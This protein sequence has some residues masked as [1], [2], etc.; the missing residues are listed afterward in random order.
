[1]TTPASSPTDDAAAVRSLLG[2]TNPVPEMSLTPG[3][4]QSARAGLAMVRVAP[5]PPRPPRGRFVVAGAVATLSVATLIAVVAI[6]A[7]RDPATTSLATGPGAK[8]VGA[9]VAATQASGT[10]RGLLTITHAGGTVTASGTGD[11]GS[12]EA[13]AEIALAGDPRSGTVTV[14]RTWTGIYAR[15]PEGM[16]PLSADRPWVSVD[17]PTLARLTQLALG[18]GAAQITGAPLDALTYLRGVSGDVTLVGPDTTRGEPTT[19]Y[20]GAVDPTK[21]AAQ[22]PEAIRAHAPPAA[23]GPASLPADLWIDGQGRLRKLVIT[24]HSAAGSAE[25]SAVVPPAGP[26]PTTITLETITLELWDFGIPV[27]VSAPPADQVADVSGL[28][29]TFVQNLGRP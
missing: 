9:A 2:P 24:E 28:L 14:L 23:A 15:L 16:N 19:H 18:D 3:E 22:L 1:V 17:A 29:G 6:P 26:G 5:A 11:F 8:A 4:V 10:A 7:G 20:R 21:A 27:E 25:D 12:G 13:R